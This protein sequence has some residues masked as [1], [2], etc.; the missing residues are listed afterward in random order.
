MTARVEWKGSITDELTP[1]LVTLRRCNPDD[2]AD[3][4]T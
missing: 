4:A 1:T 2:P 3:A